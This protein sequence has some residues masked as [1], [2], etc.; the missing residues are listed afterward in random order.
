[1]CMATAHTS[2]LRQLGQERSPFVG[3]PVVSRQ[4]SSSGRVVE[5]QEYVVGVS[6][7]VHVADP[8]RLA[9]TQR[10]AAVQTVVVLRWV[11][12]ATGF[13]GHHHTGV[14]V[15][16]QKTPV[17][18]LD[19]TRRTDRWTTHTN[20]ERSVLVVVARAHIDGSVK[21]A[22]RSGSPLVL[23]HPSVVGDITG[24]NDHVLTR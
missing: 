5:P 4:P 1:M 13:V 6:C 20:G 18:D 8:R 23:R 16:E 12:H 19:D 15:D 21:L 2:D 10:S 22:E 9:V 17:V 14:R 24:D 11:N 7:V 3:V